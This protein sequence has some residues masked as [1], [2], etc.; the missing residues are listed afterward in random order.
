MSRD[1]TEVTVQEL[2]PCDIH[3]MQRQQRVAASVDGKT[4][5]GPWA[6]MC[7]DCF[8]AYGIGL[9]LGRGQ[10]LRLPGESMFEVVAEGV[11]VASD[12]E[13]GYIIA[14]TDDDGVG[15]Q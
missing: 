5:Q 3:M 6:N 2:P 11:A 10:R 15:E 13:G 9:G 1:G 4:T 8:A 12:G 14:F 7:D